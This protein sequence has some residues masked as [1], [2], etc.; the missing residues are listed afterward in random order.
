[1]PPKKPNSFAFTTDYNGIARVLVNDVGVEAVS[2]RAGKDDG[3]IDASP[4]M[5][6][7]IWDTGATGTHITQRVV[8]DCGLKPITM[9]EV[10]GATG[11]R[12][13]ETFLVDLFLPNKLVLPAARVS[14]VD[15]L[16]D[17]DV[18]IGMD[19]IGAG[20]FAITHSQG[21]TKFSFRIPSMDDIDFV[22]KKPTRYL[23]AKVGRNDPCPCNSGKKYKKCCGA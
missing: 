13:C 21:R 6:R 9:T 4:R 10:H 20:D 18:L 2:I 17:C 15:Q 14:T 23:T 5:Y 8:D 3:V 19:I 12:M 22:K 7:A 16:G 11:T 1:M